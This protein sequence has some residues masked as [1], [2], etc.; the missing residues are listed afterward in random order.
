MKK[1]VK[2]AKAPSSGSARLKRRLW[3]ALLAACVVA[4]FIVAI[5]FLSAEFG[6]IPPL[7]ESDAALL[8]FAELCAI[9][10]FAAELCTR[11]SRAPDKKKFLVQN[12]LTILAI[13]PLGV[14]IRSFRAAE[15]IGLL[16]PLQSTFRAAETDA[17]MPLLLVSGRPLLAVQKWL[18]HFQVFRDF[19]ALVRSWAK[20]NI[21]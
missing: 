8:E 20:R 15:G 19:L 13:L 21:R 10:V 12:W 18:S 5:I 1:R 11:Y 2:R 16:R 4:F 6:A 14:F 7:T 17:I 9:I 3:D